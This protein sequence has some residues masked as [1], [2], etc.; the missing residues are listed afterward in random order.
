MGEVDIR[1]NDDFTFHGAPMVFCLLFF[2]KKSERLWVIH[3]LNGSKK[4]HNINVSR[5]PRRYNR[6]PL[7]TDGRIFRTMIIV[8]QG[9]ME[10]FAG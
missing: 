10:N 1:H 3:P 2:H 9:L 5:G 7:E 4:H 8:K 6:L